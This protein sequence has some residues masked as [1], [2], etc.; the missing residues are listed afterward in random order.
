LTSAVG[1]AH[2]LAESLSPKVHEVFFIGVRALRPLRL[3]ALEPEPLVSVLA[4]T[5]R[6]AQLSHIVATF[7]AQ[8]V[9]KELILVTN[10]DDFAADQVEQHASRS[11]VTHL[12]TDPALSLGQ[13]LNLAASAASGQVLAK[14]DDDDYYANSYLADAVQVMR[15]TGAGVVGKKTYFVYL[16]EREQTLL[17]YPGNESKRVGRVAGGSIVAHRDVVDRV[18]FPDRNLGEDVLFVRRAERAGFAVFSAEPQGFL[19]YR[20]NTGHTWQF[21][22]DDLLAVGTVMGSGHDESLWT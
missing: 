13:A 9:N 5:N 8:Q 16:E 11:D 15:S 14:L 7:D 3:V 1:R 12:A 19:Q 22:A 6:P 10:S 2:Q 20:A 4:V 18:P 21:T 17:V